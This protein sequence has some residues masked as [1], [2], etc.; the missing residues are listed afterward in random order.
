MPHRCRE[1][2]MV[3]CFKKLNAT[4]AQRYS[5]RIYLGKVFMRNGMLKHGTPPLPKLQ[6]KKA[7]AYAGLSEWKQ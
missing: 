7:G 6:Q 5:Q 3:K 1:S 2:I 4:Q